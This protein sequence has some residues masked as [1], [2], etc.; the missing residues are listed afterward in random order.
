[1]AIIERRPTVHDPSPGWAAPPE[2]P[3][4]RRTGVAVIFAIALVAVAVVLFVVTRPTH[5]AAPAVTTNTQPQTSTPAATAP[6][7][8]T[9]NTTTPQQAS[10]AAILAD[11]RTAQGIL[12]AD[13]TSYPAN[14]LDPRLAQ[15]MTGA[16]LRTVQNNLTVMRVQ[17]LHGVGTFNLTPVVS[18]I[19]GT[20]A[21]ITDCIFDHTSTVNGRTGQVTTAADTTTTKNTITM[22]LDG[23]TWKISDNQR[24][25]TGCIPSA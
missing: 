22:V 11:Y 25:G 8:S 24:V 20:T 18:A 21:T 10:T 9:S 15:H 1:M 14:P 4:R 7:A 12:L 3:R 2:P 16:E 13:A 17:G 6:V 5:K 23:G 19:D